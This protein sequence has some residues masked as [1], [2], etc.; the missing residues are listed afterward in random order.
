MDNHKDLP[1]ILNDYIDPKSVSYEDWLRVGMALQQCGFPVSVWE[2]WSKNDPDRYHPGECAQKWQGFRGHMDP[3]SS[4]TIIHMAEQHG[5]KRQPMGQKID[6]EHM[7]SDE[8]WNMPIDIDSI[9]DYDDDY[10]GEENYY[11]PPEEEY[12]PSLRV[13]DTRWVQDEDIPRPGEALGV[14]GFNPAKEVSTYLETL[15]N[16]DEYVGIV[17]KSYERPDKNG[18]KYLPSKGVFDKTAG[19][20][21]TGISKHPEDLGASIYDWNP[22]AGAWVRFNPLDGHGVSDANVTAYRYALVECDTVPIKRQYALIKQLQLPV[23]LLVHSG[24][25][26]LHAIVRIDADTMQEY[27]ERVDHLYKVCKANGLALDE[28]NR[29][30]SRLSRLPGIMRGDQP[31][32]I[33]SL[34]CGLSSFDEWNDYIDEINDELPDIENLN[35]EIMEGIPPLAPELITGILRKGHK[36]LLAGPS[37][38]G[39]SFALIELSIAIATGTKWLG[40]Y[41]CAPGKVLYVNLELDRVSCLHRFQDVY[42]ALDIP[43]YKRHYDRI[44]IWNLRGKSEPMDK[45][46]PKLI[47][48][49]K[50]MA[51]TAVIIDPI[52]KVIT[53]DENSA[54]QMAKFCNE[55]DKLALELGSSVIYCHHHSKSAGQYR[56]SID[57]SSGSGVFA[58]DPDA[59]LDMTEIEMNEERTDMLEDRVTAAIMADYLNRNC[60]TAREMMENDEALDPSNRIIMLTLAR[61]TLPADEFE[62][63]Q[64][65]V[66]IKTRSLPYV[67][68]WKVEATL[69]EFRTPV[70]GYLF[71]DYPIHKMDKFAVLYEEKE[72]GPMFGTDEAHQLGRDAIQRRVTDNTLLFS[73]AVESTGGNP[74]R[75]LEFMNANLKRPLTE[76]TLR[77][78]AKR[79]G[80]TFDRKRQIYVEAKNCEAPES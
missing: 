34:Q 47:R 20:F 30:P 46:T 42:N 23:A 27:R 72:K 3:V 71:F 37:K 40:Q 67:T 77:N 5:Y 51:Y 7:T 65:M 76:R 48:R 74:Q 33:V 75:V 55:F 11:E 31:Q 9:P 53:G 38:A 13:I 62:A 61:E 21:L 43:E 15:F 52:Y 4:G 41:Q 2:D 26:S 14:D 24:G 70:P 44:E 6:W 12:D 16:S 19:E 58:R 68:G 79:A 49:A 50:E 45:L 59:I 35:T 10:D 18:V 54:E 25:K 80:Y 78:Y 8:I 29:N 56:K 66:R 63:F 57:R 22:L 28:Q 64:N 1:K 60:P 32:Y 36:M 17:T 69:R 39:K 73:T